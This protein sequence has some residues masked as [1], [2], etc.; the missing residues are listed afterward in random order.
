MKRVTAVE[1]EASIAART[2][3]GAVARLVDVITRTETYGIV[4]IPV[5]ADVDRPEGAGIVVQKAIVARRLVAA[6]R[7][8]VVHVDAKVL[9][10]TNDKTYVC[11]TSRVH[12]RTAN[13]DLI[14]LGF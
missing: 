2:V 5:W 12:A 9:R 8:G 3:E 14:R 10:D 6:V 13:A 7:A 4:V 1:I 11:A